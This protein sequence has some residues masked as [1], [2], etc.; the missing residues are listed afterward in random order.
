MIVSTV[1]GV[2]QLLKDKVGTVDYT[3]GTISIGAIVYEDVG[4]DNEL[5]IYGR[6]K[7]LDIETNANK[8]LQVVSG[9]LVV[10][11]RGIRA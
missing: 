4:L 10:S 11:A 5:E 3:N 1:N 7:K 8:V 6:T 2:V 9:N